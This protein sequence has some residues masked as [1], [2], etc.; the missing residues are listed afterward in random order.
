M[1]THYIDVTIDPVGVVAY[2]AHDNLTV[3]C[4]AIGCKDSMGLKFFSIV[5]DSMHDIGLC[6]TELEEEYLNI[7]TKTCN[8][9][10]D[11]SDNGTLLLCGVVRRSGNNFSKELEILVQGQL[12]INLFNIIIFPRGS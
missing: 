12:Y 10:V 4:T 2:I 1:H 11:M 9:T 5:N 3:T 7:K 6:T 8:S